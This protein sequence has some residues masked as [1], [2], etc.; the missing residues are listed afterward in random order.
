MDKYI[1]THTHIQNGILPSQ[2]IKGHLSHLQQH[3]MDLMGI[4]LSELLGRERLIPCDFTYMWELLKKLHKQTKQ[5]KLTDT[6]KRLIPNQKGSDSLV[7][8]R[9]LGDGR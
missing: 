1:Y 2:K 9:C 8:G 6:E 7:K 4:K 5:N 3:T